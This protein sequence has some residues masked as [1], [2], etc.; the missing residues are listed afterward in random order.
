MIPRFLGVL[1]L[2]KCSISDVQICHANCRTQGPPGP[3]HS[4][5]KP[6]TPAAALPASCQSFQCLLLR[7]F[8]IGDTENSGPT[9]GSDCSLLP[10]SPPSPLATSLP[11]SNCPLSLLSAPSEPGFT[12]ALHLPAAGPWPSYPTPQAAVSPL[13]EWV[14]SRGP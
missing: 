6:H 2:C 9:S 14:P 8:P 4:L 10:A 3:H 13:L 12:P 11:G 5:C 1:S 7:L